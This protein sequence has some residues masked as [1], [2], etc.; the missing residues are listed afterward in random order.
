MIQA[1]CRGARVTVLIVLLAV[2]ADCRFTTDPSEM[3]LPGTW[4]GHVT[5]IDGGV[6][7]QLWLQEDGEGN[8]SG[9]VS[10]TDFRRIPTPSETISRGT[11]S[12]VQVFSDISLTLDY[13]TSSGG[14]SRSLQI[15]RSHQRFH[16]ARHG[17][18][19]HRHAGIQADPTKSR[20]RPGGGPPRRRPGRGVRRPR[21]VTRT[22]GAAGGRLPSALL[23]REPVSG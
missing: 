10:R 8:V 21:W 13:E 17:R 9:T 18:A 5:L 6:A 3:P 2:I 19:R 15:R 7:W 16:T 4:L 11:V 20:C 23:F 14:L 1:I 22:I 12:G